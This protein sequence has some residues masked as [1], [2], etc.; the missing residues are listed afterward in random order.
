MKTTIK[1]I[2][3]RLERVK[4]ALEEQVEI[5]NEIDKK[6]EEFC[7]YFDDI[8]LDN[9]ETFECGEFCL[10]IEIYP[11]I[12]K[13]MVKSYVK[14]N[15]T[16]FEETKDITITYSVD[17]EDLQEREDYSVFGFE[18]CESDFEEALKDNEIERLTTWSKEYNK[19][20]LQLLALNKEKTLLTSTL[21][22]FDE[23][24]RSQIKIDN[25]GL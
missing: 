18:M 3:D 24:E 25:L 23:I 13:E 22:T 16:T 1:I 4:K 6:L 8:E 2:K 17:Y 9:I 7:L 12:T 11:T 10:D 19:M 5:K 21:E 14:W 15:N 20:G